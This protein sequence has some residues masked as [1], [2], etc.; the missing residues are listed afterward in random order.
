MQ[1]ITVAIADPDSA[2]LVACKRMLRDDPDILVVG[3]T[4]GA[5]D[6]VAEI[7]SLNPRILLFNL[8]LCAD[9]DCAVLRA[10]R[11]D[12][13]ATRVLLLPDHRVKEIRLL[14]ALAMG[15][16]GYLE[17]DV[18]ERQLVKAVH[19]L[20]RGEAWVSRKMLG[21]IMEIVLR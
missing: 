21:K 17:Y 3:Q 19:G 14:H 7:R 8:G 16:R 10:L 12:C 2:G 20:D 6:I 9:A 15:A 1:T 5:K 13:P 18:V 11:R 4:N